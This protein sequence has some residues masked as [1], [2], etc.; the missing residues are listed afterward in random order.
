MRKSPLEEFG[1]RV[2]RRREALGLSQEELAAKAG[3][4]R[5]YEGSVERGERNLA[6]INILRL[7]KALGMDAGTLL[8]GLKI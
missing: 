8:R 5:N 3:I 6:L 7:A 1:W 4:H 2:R